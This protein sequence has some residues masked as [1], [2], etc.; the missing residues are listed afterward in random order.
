MPFCRI[1]TESERMVPLSSPESS[2][3]NVQLL[4]I[5]A[6]PDNMPLSPPWRYPAPRR[7]DL[8]RQ[9]VGTPSG[10][11]LPAISDRRK[12]RSRAGCKRTKSA[13][14]D[15]FAHPPFHECRVN[16]VLRPW[17]CFIYVIFR[18]LARRSK[19]WIHQDDVILLLA[20]LD[21]GKAPLGILGEE[22]ALVARTIGGTCR[23]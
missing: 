5:T 20:E 12:G 1:V 7:Q 19:W 14:G 18:W 23:V 6:P 22:P 10:E 17:I 3:I 15:E 8:Q 16:I 13:V 21:E 11:F 2:W 9:P 4:L